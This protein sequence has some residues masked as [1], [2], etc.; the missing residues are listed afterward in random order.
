MQHSG[1][2]C[3]MFC[4]DLCMSFLP[5]ECMHAYYTVDSLR[6]IAPSIDSLR[7]IAPSIDSLRAIALSIDSLRVIA[8]SID[9]LRAIALSIDSLRVIA[10]SIDSLRAI[11]PSIDSLRAIAL[12]ID[13]L[14]LYRYVCLSGMPCSNKA[15]L[16]VILSV[17][18]SLMFDCGH[19]TERFE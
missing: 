10:L 11:A 2:M 3:C 7:V 13:S 14:R 4:V 19:K 16:S 17:G 8:L 5:C 1:C 6:V 9:S 12:S 15:Y 18:Q